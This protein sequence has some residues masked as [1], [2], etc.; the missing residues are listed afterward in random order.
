LAR[1]FL[2]GEEHISRFL[3][4]AAALLDVESEIT[5]QN[6]IPPGVAKFQRGAVDRRWRPFELDERSDGGLI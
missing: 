5:L 3:A 2:G 1:L 4:E 6:E